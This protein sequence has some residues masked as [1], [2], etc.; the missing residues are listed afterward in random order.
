MPSTDPRAT[1]QAIVDGA[2]PALVRLSHWVHAN[3]EV[4]FEERLAAGW[5][6]DWLAAARF[7]VTRGV[8]GLETA[9]S[10]TFGEGSLHVAVIAE[11]DALPGV[12]H[13][14]G[15]N[16]I[17]AA[18]VGAGLAL[19]GVADDLDLRVTV[20]GTPA[21]EGGGGKIRLIEAG[22]FDDVHLAL[23]V[24]PAPRDTLRPAILAAQ[25]LDIAYRGR[26]A[27]AAGA[28]E[29]GINA[30]D[31]LVIAQAAIGL[32]RQHLPAGSRVHGIVTRGGDAPNIVPAATE[33]RWMV[34]A[35][36]ATALDEVRERV[37]RCFEAGALATGAELSVTPRVRYAHLEQDP[38]LLA[39]YERA[40]LA[41]GRRL[42]A[43]EASGLGPV[44]TDMGDVSLVVPSIHPMIG[45]DPGDAVNHQPAFTAAAAAPAADRAVRDGALAMAWAVIDVAGQPDVRERLRSGRRSA[46]AQDED[47]LVD[48]V[49]DE[50]VGVSV[51]S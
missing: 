28:P 29:L 1:A 44:S 23:M 11:Y 12:G 51:G 43:P 6:G 47:V 14:C 16:V 19:A 5:V 30:A 39:A 38:D 36:T 27:H 8:G 22:L 25:T 37:L 42:V 50:P 34:R 48:D 7:D 3:P 15:H 35:P 24:H 18:G 32:L 41:L 45:I 17:C 10:G 26:E 2:R 33:A 21:E 40:A 20:F 4:A 46:G 49:R 31:A 9:V 13:A